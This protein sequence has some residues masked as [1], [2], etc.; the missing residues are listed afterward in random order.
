[1]ILARFKRGQRDRFTTNGCQRPGITRIA[2]E[3]QTF[4]PSWYHSCASERLTD[5]LIPLVTWDRNETLRTTRCNDWTGI[6]CTIN[7]WQRFSTIIISKPF[8]VH[9][10][11]FMAINKQRMQLCMKL[12]KTYYRRTIIL[13]DHRCSWNK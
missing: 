2:R 4:W 9:L 12:I 5:W 3:Q 10:L 11:L 13:I 6:M 1:M 7:R 8:K